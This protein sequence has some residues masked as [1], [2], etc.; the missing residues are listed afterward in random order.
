MAWEIEFTEGA[1]KQLS[2][3]GYSEAKRVRDF[4]FKRVAA[5]Q[6]PRILGAAL[7]GSELGGYWRY[8]LG[9]YRI[10]CEIHDERVVVLVVGIG[11]R[12]EIYS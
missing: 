5:H 9:D 7:Q 6:N 1:K 8:R 10:I 2:N 11:H 12:R 3:L 4:L